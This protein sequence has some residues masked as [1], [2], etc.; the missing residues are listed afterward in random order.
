[1]PTPTELLEQERITISKL[2]KQIEVQNQA[3]IINRGLIADKNNELVICA[4]T[5]SLLKEENNR[6][7]Q[8]LNTK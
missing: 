8:Q 3:L 1:M 2:T 5:I 4:K 6:L 7:K